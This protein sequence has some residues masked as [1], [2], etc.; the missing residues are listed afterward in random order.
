MPKLSYS[1]RRQR[2]AR[3][4]LAG[5]TQAGLPAGAINI[6]TGIQASFAAGAFRHR[7]RRRRAPWRP[8]RPGP[9]RDVLAAALKSPSVLK[10]NRKKDHAQT[11]STCEALRQR[12]PVT[13]ALAA[14]LFAGAG[15][16]TT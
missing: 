8:G 9:L 2:W 6:V 16:H 7:D 1:W 14:E 3:A 11:A 13:R 12:R 5:L 15:Y 4:W 10:T